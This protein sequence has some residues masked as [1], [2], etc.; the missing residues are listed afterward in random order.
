M[1]ADYSSRKNGEK[2]AHKNTAANNYF[3]PEV[4]AQIVLFQQF[5]QKSS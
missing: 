2:G 5:S 3:Y 1:I 4:A